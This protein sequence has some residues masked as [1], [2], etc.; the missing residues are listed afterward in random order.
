MSNNTEKKIYTVGDL[1][2]AMSIMTDAKNNT[3]SE[4]ACEY[5]DAA[6]Y[7]EKTFK[8][9]N[10]Q[11][12]SNQ[13]N[14]MSSLKDI[15]TRRQ[16][17]VAYPTKDSKSGANAL[18]SVSRATRFNVSDFITS[19][20]KEGTPVANGKEYLDA[21]NGL[22]TALMRFIQSEVSYDQN[23]GK[24]SVPVS[25]PVAALTRVMSCIGIEGVIARNRDV[26]FLA[27]TVSGGSASIGSLRDVSPERVSSQ[28]MDVYHVQMNGLKYEFETQGKEDQSAP[29][30][31]VKS[32]KA[33]A[34]K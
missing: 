7:M 5:F 28:L 27:Y 33:K 14:E 25:V 20:E 9:Y 31:A 15:F 2:T 12:L 6:D 1:R 21:I 3:D 23:G 30:P 32:N 8:A 22:S 10:E 18:K 11:T 4:L 24:K 26:R 13:Y 29:A 19:K 16:Y 17:P 34:K